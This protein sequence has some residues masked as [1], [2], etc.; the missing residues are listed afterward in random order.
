MNVSHPGLRVAVA[1][2]GI[3]GETVAW[4]LARRGAAVTVY[5]PDPTRATAR[6]AAGMLAP[7]TE[8]EFGESDLLSANLA[9][10]AIWP[11]FVAELAAESGRECGHAVTGALSVAVDADELALIDRHAEFVIECGLGAQRLSGRDARRR[12]PSLSPSTRGA[13]FVPGDHH[14]DPRLVLDA[15]RSANDALG[16]EIVRGT[17]TAAAAT[18]IQVR[19]DSGTTDVAAD[20]VVVAA[21]WSTGA[22]IDLPVR[23]VK[24]QILRLRDTGRSVVPTH[25]VRGVEVYIVPR[26][27]G[28]I[29]VGATSEDRGDD[30]SVT[31]GAVRYLLERA[32]R[33]VPGLD[34]AELV[35]ASAGL[36]PGTP[37][38]AP[39]LDT[40]DGVFVAA[41][42][43]RNGVLLAPWTGDA[44]AAAVLDGAWPADAA[45]FR[46]DRF[47]PLAYTSAGSS[48]GEQS[49]SGGTP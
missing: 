12:E 5:D 27:S 48:A 15:L 34:E 35:E 13:W 29:V 43:H 9:S 32:N 31:A 25:V 10:V 7:V 26:S 40:V 16:V 14:V 11:T 36:R 42:H 41:G 21:G 18:Q 1:G 38:H 24:G 8:A 22:L 45:P 46:A 30:R 37:D 44:V 47:G 39:I 6:V 20:A 49:A 3:I 4:R 2:A 17:V 33:L 28:E 19:T 23:P